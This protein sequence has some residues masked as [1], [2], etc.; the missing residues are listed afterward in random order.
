KPAGATLRPV[1]RPAGQG[2]AG[3]SRTGGGAGDTPCARSLFVIASRLYGGNRRRPGRWTGFGA[4]RGK[5]RLE[6]VHQGQFVAIGQF[7]QTA[8]ETNC[9][10]GEGIVPVRRQ[11]PEIDAPGGW[12]L[13][14]LNTG[15][16]EFEI[17]VELGQD[18]L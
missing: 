4:L 11:L 1:H 7:M 2:R 5:R 6:S 16:A 9:E 15:G 3:T 14:R 17:V 13:G 18:H 8:A 10:I 12:R